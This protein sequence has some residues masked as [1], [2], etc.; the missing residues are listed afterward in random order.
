WQCLNIMGYGCFT[1]SSATVSRSCCILAPGATGR[2]G[3]T[4][5]ILTSCVTFR[6]CCSTTAATARATSHASSK[7]IDSRSM[8]PM[9][10]PCSITW[11]CLVRRSGGTRTVV[12][13]TR[14]I[15]FKKR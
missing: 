9:S 8:S 6:W 14:L 5:G 12:V 3:A 10:S 4:P 13:A 1:R 11:R 15:Q 2:C 7:P